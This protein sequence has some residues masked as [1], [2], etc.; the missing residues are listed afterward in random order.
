M[1]LPFPPTPQGINSLQTLIPP[2]YSEYESQ[3]QRFHTPQGINSL[4]T[5]LGVLDVLEQSIVSIPLKALIPFKPMAYK[6][7]GVAPGYTVSIPLKALIP[8]KQNC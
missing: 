4:Q 6:V 8:F 7:G 5:S 3:I 2:E 1:L